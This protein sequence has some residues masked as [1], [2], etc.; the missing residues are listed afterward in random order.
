MLQFVL[1]RRKITRNVLD[2]GL[3]LYV[4]FVIYLSRFIVVILST[5]L[6]GRVGCHLLVRWLAGAVVK[7]E[8]TT[9]L[10][11]A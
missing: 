5:V 4:A 1:V 2:L 7:V 10:L 3:N 9:I 8:G 6:G 11:D